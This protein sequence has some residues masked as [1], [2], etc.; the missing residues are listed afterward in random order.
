MSVLFPWSNSSQ[1]ATVAP[2]AG[3]ALYLYAVYMSAVVPVLP[4]GEILTISYGLR[5]SFPNSIDFF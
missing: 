4:R 1:S 5:L 3:I 2:G